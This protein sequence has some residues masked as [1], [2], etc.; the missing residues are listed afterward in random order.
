MVGWQLKP[1][2]GSGVLFA[3]K[4]RTGAVTY[5]IL[6]RQEN[7]KPDING[8]IDAKPNVMKR[9]DVTNSFLRLAGGELIKIQLYNTPTA[10]RRL[11][12]E[13]VDDESVRVLH[14]KAGNP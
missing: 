10:N 1:I 11:E 7:G 12:F 3:G 8:Y 13:V 5:E 14:G 4:T 9:V 2:R 6:V